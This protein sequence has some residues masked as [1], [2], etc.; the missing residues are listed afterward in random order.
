MKRRRRRRAAGEFSLDRRSE[1]DTRRVLAI[2]DD[3]ERPH[4]RRRVTVAD[5]ER[6]RETLLPPHQDDADVEEGGPQ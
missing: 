6:F 4:R 3:L 1:G 5:H 2:L